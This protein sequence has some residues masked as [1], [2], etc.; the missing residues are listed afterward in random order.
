MNSVKL[1]AAIHLHHRM[2]PNIDTDQD[3]L[4]SQDLCPYAYNPGHADTDTDND[5][6]GDICDFG[7]ADGDGMGPLS[8]FAL[9]GARITV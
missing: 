1:N 4:N 8:D 2:D 5:G 7:D 3:I 9:R 6:I